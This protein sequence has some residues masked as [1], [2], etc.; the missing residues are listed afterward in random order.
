MCVIGYEVSQW[1]ICGKNHNQP[2]PPLQAFNLK[3]EH[4]NEEESPNLKDV[5]CNQTSFITKTPHVTFY[6]SSG[7]RLI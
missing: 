5:V 2:Q 1:S 6:V 7:D 3:T 4:F